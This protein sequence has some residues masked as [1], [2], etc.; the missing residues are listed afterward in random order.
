MDLSF[1]HVVTL[2]EEPE[3]FI[4]V[5]LQA[6]VTTANN[7]TIT[8]SRDSTAIPKGVPGAHPGRQK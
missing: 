2:I 5:I 1:D 4:Q 7:H 8:V 6:S 3:V